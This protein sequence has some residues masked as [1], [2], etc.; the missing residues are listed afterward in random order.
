[1]VGVKE[2]ANKKFVKPT[3]P[4]LA[5]VDRFTFAP[6]AK[7]KARNIM[8]AFGIAAMEKR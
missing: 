4:N 6:A 5:A 2:N 1:M 7:E 8:R 3:C